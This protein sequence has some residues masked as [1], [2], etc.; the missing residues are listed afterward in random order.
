MGSPSVD[1]LHFG[2]RSERTAGGAALY[3]ALAARRAGANVTLVGPRPHPMPAELAPVDELLDWRGPTVSPDA[4]PHFEIVQEPGGVTTYLKGI[5]GS[6]GHPAPDD[7][8]SD[9]TPGIAHVV[10]MRDPA[11]QVLIA[12][13]LK[14]EG[15]TVAC[16]TYGGATG[17]RRAVVLDAFDIADLFFCNESEAETLFGSAER[18]RTGP[19]RVLFVTLGE[20]GARVFE[21]DEMTR[22]EGVAVE[23][24]D[25]TGA[26]DTFCGTVLA[27]L[28]R[29]ADPV[30]AAR[31]GVAA[32]ADMITGVGPE[33]LLDAP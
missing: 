23:E 3:T 2:G 32:A 12:A 30:E 19:G 16:G 29:G 22:I 27:H 6:D 17:K 11:S 13:R 9:L 21:G 10:P 15:W 20:R 33:R 8:P 26:G 25:P 4:L 18:A 24:L 5:W 1:L 31:L 14:N 28:A 7:V